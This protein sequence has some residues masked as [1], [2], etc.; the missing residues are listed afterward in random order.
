MYT[1]I[2]D[3][4]IIERVARWLDSHAV[5]QGEDREDSGTLW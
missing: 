3:L 5:S 4:M 2:F 1:S